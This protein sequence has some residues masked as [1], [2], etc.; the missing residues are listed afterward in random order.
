MIELKNADLEN[1]FSELYINNINY[2]STSNYKKLYYFLNLFFNQDNRLFLGNIKIDNKNTYIL[3]LLDYESISNQLM[4]KKGTLLYEYII[5]DLIEQA[6]LS[7]IKEIIENKLE[8]LLDDIVTNSNIEYNYNFNIDISKIIN[9]FINISMD[10][11]IENYLN[12]IKILINNLKQKNMKK[13]IIVFINEKIFDNKLDDIDGIICFNF[14]STKFPNILIGDEIINV[15]L[16]LLVNQVIMNWPCTVEIEKIESIILNFFKH[17]QINNDIYTQNIEEYIGFKL[18]NKIL[19]LNLNI[20]FNT[21][22]IENM[23]L[24]YK[25]YI[26]QL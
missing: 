9:N 17:I 14:N 6:E 21:E 1:G 19:N 25:N 26:N 11:S 15:D 3:N 20:L 16:N 5:G 12:I 24:I 22:N 2:V 18:I 7:D 23:P 13:R 4:L 8:N 10:L